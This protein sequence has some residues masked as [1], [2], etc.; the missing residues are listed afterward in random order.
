[1]AVLPVSTTTDAEQQRL[2]RELAQLQALVTAT[3]LGIPLDF[4]AIHTVASRLTQA[5]YEGWEKEALAA[6][7][8]KPLAKT[9]GEPADRPH[10][11]G[12]PLRA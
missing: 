3:P 9:V 8:R 10:R 2:V 4:R 6:T 7:A 11:P 1:M 12:S 5:A